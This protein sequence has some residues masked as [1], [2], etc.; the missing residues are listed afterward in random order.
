MHACPHGDEDSRE[1][2]FLL[3]F[4]FVAWVK[5]YARYDW[6]S[7]IVTVVCGVCLIFIVLTSFSK[8]GAFLAEH[9]RQASKRIPPLFP[10][11]GQSSRAA[12]PGM[13]DSGETARTGS[14]HAGAP[15][16][17]NATAL[18][19]AP[20]HMTAASASMMIAASATAGGA[21]GVQP[22]PGV[23]RSAST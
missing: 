21:A 14:S 9:R 23:S 6:A 5:F 2:S 8:W 19:V 13:R 15:P 17:G 10:P 4:T 7:G 16:T 11:T 22:L 20:A 1:N 3:N 12:D 18:I